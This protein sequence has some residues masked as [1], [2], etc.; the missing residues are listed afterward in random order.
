MRK[1]GGHINEREV[2]VRL[3]DDYQKLIFSIC[4]KITKDYFAAE[5]L[6]QETFISAFQN[7]HRFALINEKAYIARIATNKSIDYLRSSTNRLVPTEETFFKSQ[8]DISN[9]PEAVYLQVEI[10]NK[11][12]RCIKGLK[13]PYDEI[14]GAYYM[15]EKT[16]QEI[17]L[18]RGQNL[19]TIQTQIYRAREMLKSLY[20][21]EE[22]DEISNR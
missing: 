6:T 14:A 2:I 1:V 8:V 13:P 22:S 17:A 15:E 5:D 11:L 20:R 4:Y 10:R 12:T 21:K 18:K 19:K 9:Q 16:P 3:I 7:L